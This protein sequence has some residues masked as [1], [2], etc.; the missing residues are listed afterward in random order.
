MVER[1]KIKKTYHIVQFRIDLYFTHIGHNSHF[2]SWQ[3]WLY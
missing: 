3:R 2:H 1:H